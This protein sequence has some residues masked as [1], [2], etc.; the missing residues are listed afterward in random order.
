MHTP[1]VLCHAM[2]VGALIRVEQIVLLDAVAAHLSSR[3][4]KVCARIIR[5]VSLNRMIVSEVFGTHITF[6]CVLDPM[7]STEPFMGA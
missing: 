2:G 3:N 7:V 4:C 6:V 1:K 5:L